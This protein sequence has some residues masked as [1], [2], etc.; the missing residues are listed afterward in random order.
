[1]NQAWLQVAGLVLDVLGFGVIAWEWILAQRAE[2]KLWAIEQEQRKPRGY[3]TAEDKRR[4]AKFRSSATR[5]WFARR[6]Y[7]AI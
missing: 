7:R 6:R 4:L 5:H 3:M 1:M 2:R